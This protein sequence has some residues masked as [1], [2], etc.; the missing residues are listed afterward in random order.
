MTWLMWRQH[1][2]GT[3]VAAVAFVVFAVAAVLTGV[4]MAN[5]YA[6]LLQ[7]CQAPGGCVPGGRLFQGY[8]AIIDSV[9]LT[10]LVP[11][12]L[13]AFLGATLIADETEHATNV[14]VWTQSV[15]RRR[16]LSI[17]VGTALAATVVLS[18]AIS[19]LGT[20]W[21]GTPNSLDGNRFEGAQFA[22]QN[23]V[24]VAYALFAV[25]FGIAAGS[26]LRRTLPAVAVTVGGYVVA[27]L[28]VALYARPHY[29]RA[30][31]LMLP[32]EKEPRLPSGSWTV[33]T[34]L[35]DQAGH[36]LSGPVR[37]PAGCADSV[38][39]GP[40]PD[41]LDRLGYHLVVRYHPAS[42]YWRFQWIEFGLYTAAAVALVA[43]ALHWTA[44]RDA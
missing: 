9:H 26:V 18:S 19:A 33:S 39:R 5:L 12:L 28:L 1:R 17:K 16:W 2:G 11:P 8:G 31:T 7:G 42:S 30:V 15:T 3:I 35:V 27:Q 22:T 36:V 43:F 29:E 40:G 13:G 32:A 21:S 4:H 38:M 6:D 44:R 10:I 25:A 23:V 14:L 37:V 34:D 20:W 41:C 24:P